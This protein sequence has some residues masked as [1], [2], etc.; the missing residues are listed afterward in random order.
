MDKEELKE[1]EEEIKMQIKLTVK[2]LE[3]FW[4]ELQKSNLPDEIKKQILLNYG[5]KES[6]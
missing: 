5:S 4:D 3:I 6:K 1:Y 2:A